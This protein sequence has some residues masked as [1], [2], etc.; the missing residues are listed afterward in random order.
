MTKEQAQIAA[1]QWVLM[2]QSKL[3]DSPESSKRV[4]N[5]KL[6]ELRRIVQDKGES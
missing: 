1:I 6:V 4:I 3:G 2:I 5:D